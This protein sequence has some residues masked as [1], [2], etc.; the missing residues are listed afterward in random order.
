MKRV[1]G[2]LKSGFVSSLLLCI[3]FI[4]MRGLHD[5][6]SSI[7]VSESA[8]ARGYLTFFLVMFIFQTVFAWM[9]LGEDDRNKPRDFA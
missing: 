4:A 8:D 2:A 3:V 6:W 7:Q 9:L 5:G 1:F